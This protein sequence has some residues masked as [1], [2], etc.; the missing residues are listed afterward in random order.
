MTTLTPAPER[1]EAHSMAFRKAYRAA[2][3]AGHVHLLI[4]MDGVLYDWDERFWNEVADRFPHVVI[5]DLSDRRSFDPT[6]SAPG[7]TRE[8][9]LEVFDLPGFYLG[10][11]PMPGA[12]EALR[13]FELMGLPRNVLSS[14]T[15]TNPD[16]ASNKYASMARDFSP[17]WADLTHLARDK[18]STLGTLL[19]DDKPDIH[20]AWYYP[21]WDQV[22]FDWP[23]NDHVEGRRMV[24]WENWEDSLPEIVEWRETNKRKELVIV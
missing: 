3:P 17:V 8:Q 19:V 13:E 20:G 18:T 24:S 11:K 14:P 4:D 22:I 5:P 10:L 23:Y 2:I 7:L 16:C 1:N 21:T 9:M 6:V 12:Q 15:T